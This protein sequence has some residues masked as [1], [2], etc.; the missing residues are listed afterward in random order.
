MADHISDLHFHKTS[1][2]TPL[3]TPC[4]NWCMSKC[5]SQCHCNCNSSPIIFSQDC[6][7]AWCH[8]SRQVVLLTAGEK[9][10]T[11]TFDASWVG[12]INVAMTNV[13]RKM[14]NSNQPWIVESVI[15]AWFQ[16][17][18]EKTSFVTSGKCTVFPLVQHC[19]HSGI[20]CSKRKE[21][22]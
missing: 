7:P 14:K 5:L 1:L 17:K 3:Q 6:L 4:Q 20:S 9:K 8:K 2:A 18:G 12:T 22:Q 15:V 13:S 16:N 10:E 11:A 19:P 21:K